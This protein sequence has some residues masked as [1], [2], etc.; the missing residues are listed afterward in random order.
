[1]L[2][3]PFTTLALHPCKSFNIISIMPPPLILRTDAHPSDKSDAKRIEAE[4]GYALLRSGALGWG[5]DE[6]SRSVSIRH[7]A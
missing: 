5:R 2:E 3:A 4:A 1:M 6:L 7:A